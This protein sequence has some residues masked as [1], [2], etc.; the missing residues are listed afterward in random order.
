MKEKRTIF[1]LYL[2]Q[3]ERAQ[4]EAIRRKYNQESKS[5]GIRHIMKKEYDQINL[6]SRNSEA[7]VYNDK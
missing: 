6:E 3:E 7:E 4:A 5:S 2:N 1:P